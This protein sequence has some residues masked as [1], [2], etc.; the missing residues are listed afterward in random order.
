[1][2]SKTRKLDGEEDNYDLSFILYINIC[3]KISFT[4]KYISSYFIF[5]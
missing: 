1:M 5:E 2:Y 4:K 3:E